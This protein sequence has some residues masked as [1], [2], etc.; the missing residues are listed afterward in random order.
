MEMAYSTLIQSLF[1]AYLCRPSGLLRKFLI[2]ASTGFQPQ[3]EWPQAVWSE[4]TGILI[5]MQE[6]LRLCPL[7]LTLFLGFTSE[8]SSQQLGARSCFSSIFMRL[9]TT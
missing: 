8:A 3:D 5:N 1:N 9:V 4:A 6:W 2:F 7:W